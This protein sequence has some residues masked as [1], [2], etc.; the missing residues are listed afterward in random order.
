MRYYA[1]MRLIV[2]GG[3]LRRDSCNQRIAEVAGEGA[4]AAGADVTVLHLRN[5]AIPLFDPDDEAA[6]GPG[7]GALAL[8][9]AFREN[10]GVI[11]GVPEYNGGPPGALKNAIDWLS[12]PQEGYGR[13][14]CFAGK[15]CAL[16]S[17]S[18]GHLGGIRGLPITRT[19]LAS[20]G[21]YVL[22]S[23]QCVSSVQDKF[24]AEGVMTCDA[25][26][27]ALHALGEALTDTARRLRT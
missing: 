4:A 3:S 9:E 7:A 6:N 20:L 14:D 12:R 10:D 21:M 24:D 25:T 5:F 23:Q 19:I 27:T 1:H 15:V 22:P 16:V 26:R 2:M 13:L 8:R 17:A 18:P 11:L